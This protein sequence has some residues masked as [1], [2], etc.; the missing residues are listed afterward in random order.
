MIVI[1]PATVYNGYK[2]DKTTIILVMEI[3]HTWNSKAHT[4]CVYGTEGVKNVRS[5]KFEWM[6]RIIPDINPIKYI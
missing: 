2:T 4:M 1:V 6:Q 5:S 3:F